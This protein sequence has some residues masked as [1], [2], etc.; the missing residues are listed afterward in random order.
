MT[1]NLSELFEQIVDD[2]PERTALVTQERRLTYAQLDERATR[3]AHHLRDQ[4]VGAGDHV[5]LHLLNGTEYVEG[6][7]AAFK[8]RAVPININYRYVERELEYLYDNADL[9][10]LVFHRRF[11]PLVGTV[12]PGIATLTHLVMVDDDSGEPAPLDAV[13]YEDALAAASPARDFAGRSSDDVYCAYTGGTTGM[14]KG[15]LW[16]HEDIF[17]ASMGGGDPTMMDGPISAP[18]QLTG[19]IPEIGIVQLVTPPFMHV[20]A[21]WS[22]FHAFY[23][24]GKVVVPTPGSF[25][26][27]EAWSLI[28]AE[29]VNIITLVGDAMVRPLLEH[30]ADDPDRYE[31]ASLFAIASGGAVLSTSCKNLAQELIPNIIVID[32]YGSSETG[33]AGT[34]A[35]LPGGERTEGGRF[36]MDDRT[37]VFDDDMAP[38]EPGS[39]VVGQVARRGRIPLGYHKDPEQSAATFV[40]VDGER[41]VLSGDL[42]TVDTDGTVVLHGRGSVSINTGGEKVHPEEVESTVIGHP[43][44]RDVVVVGVPDERWGQRVVAVVEARPGHDVTLDDIQAFARE[45]LA[46][47]KLPRD[48]VLVDSLL[49]NPNGKADYA[50]ARDQATA[51]LEPDAS[52]TAPAG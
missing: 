28:D 39:G 29:G 12:A 47:Y 25:D 7:L 45:Q 33:I 40:E 22:A 18:E 6:M 23:G 14:P 48:L 50:W 3:L 27:A 8:L 46:G 26:P 31:G 38:V 9:V 32:G 4:G 24:G 37:R 34:Q 36:Q 20:S 51:A 17:F 42:A 35:R 5:G 49:R 13:D 52:E 1:Y 11:A 43:G 15:V 30:Y 19:R 16:R 10:A 41:W 2:A 21:H 44:V